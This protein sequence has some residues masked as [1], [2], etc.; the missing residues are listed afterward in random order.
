MISGGRMGQDKL[1]HQ[2]T[3]EVVEHIVRRRVAKKVI[4]DINL[5][6]DD[7]EYQIQTEK[8]NARYLLP[9]ILVLVTV[10]LFFLIDIPQLLRFISSLF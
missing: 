8:R 3:D 6:V 4:R 5:Q 2:Q 1:N 10:T 7:I 9:L